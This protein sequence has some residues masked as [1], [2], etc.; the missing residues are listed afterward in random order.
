VRFTHQALRTS[1]ELAERYINERHLPD[2][3]IDVIDE[4]GA[5]FRMS[6]KRKR[7]RVTVH[8]VEEVVS[9]IAKIPARSAT[10]SN[11]AQLKN[12]AKVLRS[13]IFGQD[14]AIDA[15]TTAVKRAQAGLNA[16]DRPT[17]CF[18]FAGP[19]G[20]GKTEVSRQ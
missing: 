16:A 15:L 6:T 12:L 11:T 17:G 18:L 8:D 7:R 9:R 4:V 10:A 5:A 1:A 3:A 2:K 19:T 20:V 13:K 14:K